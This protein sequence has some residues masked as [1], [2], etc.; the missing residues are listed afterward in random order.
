MQ[1]GLGGTAQFFANDG[2]A[3]IKGIELSAKYQPGNG[4]RIN[5][6][7]THQAIKSGAGGRQYDN[8]GPS[9]M[10]NLLA[11]RD[12][13]YGYSASLGFYYL[14]KMKQLETNDIRAEQKRVDIRLARDISTATRDYTLALVVQNLFDDEQETRLKNVIDRRAYGSVSVNFK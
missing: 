5:I 4:N 3:R 12:F 1:E 8:A 6:S 13:G 7:Y 10:L 9:D 11:I 2:K 14:S